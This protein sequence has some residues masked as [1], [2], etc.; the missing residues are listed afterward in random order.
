M[1]NT[2]DT[3]RTDACTHCGAFLLTHHT[4]AY[5]LER[6]ARLKAEADV[7]GLRSQLK[8]AVEIAEGILDPFLRITGVPEH[9]LAALKK[10]LK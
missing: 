4:Q 10:E 1:T 5:C 3:P 8:R 9:N 6:T 2:T 7:E